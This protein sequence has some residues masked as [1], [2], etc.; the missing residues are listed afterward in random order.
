MEIGTTCRLRTPKTG[1]GEGGGSKRKSESEQLEEI[2]LKKHY[3]K[4]LIGRQSY[5]QV[6]RGVTCQRCN[7]SEM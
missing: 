1:L 3:L 2:N 4:A 7:L 6:I 5:Y